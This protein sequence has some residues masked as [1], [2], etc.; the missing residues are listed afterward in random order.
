VIVVAAMFSLK[1]RQSL[2]VSE[3]DALTSELASVTKQVLGQTIS[4]PALAEAQIK[5]PKSNDPLPRFDAFDAVGALS[6]A[7]PQEISHEVKRL[8]VDFADEKAEGTFELQGSLE[9][10]GQR[11]EIVGALQKHP[12]FKEIELG[13]TNAAAGGQDRIAYQLEAKLECPGE[14]A[15]KKPG[16]KTTEASE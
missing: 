2:L 8:S 7:I 16:K 12:C 6:S 11:D 10:L 15:P 1:A 14:V 5:N 4:D 9:S 13:R 3:Q